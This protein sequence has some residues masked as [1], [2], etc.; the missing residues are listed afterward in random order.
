MLIT[1]CLLFLLFGFSSRHKPGIPPGTVKITEQLYFDETEVTNFSWKEFEYSTSIKYGKG[2]AE[3]LATLPDTNV[4]L[5]GKNKSVK[6]A[7]SYYQSAT[8][9]D[10]PVVGVSYEQAIAFCKW[11]TSMVKMFYSRAFKSEFNAE[12]RLPTE[13]EW[14]MVAYLESHK[15]AEFEKAVP[16]KC[17]LKNDS[18]NLCP[19]STKTFGKGHFGMYQL[20]G[21]VAEM[22]DEKDKSKGG[23]W[24]HF[25]EESRVGKV[26]HYNEPNKWLGFRCVCIATPI[27]K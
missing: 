26:Q 1:T 17:H 12:Y 18:N 19:V 6:L 16:G 24:Q 9:R 8:Y 27:S 13:A 3:H 25:A 10:Y 7:S 22:L 11:R 2:S 15:I 23:S 20:I 4:W 14:E 21:N 5:Q